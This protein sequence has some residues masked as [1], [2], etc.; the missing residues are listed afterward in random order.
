MAVRTFLWVTVGAW[1]LTALS[2]MSWKVDQ[3]VLRD[4]AERRTKHARNDEERILAL[5]EWVFQN[6]GDDKVSHYF[7]H[8]SLGPTPVQVLAGG[9]DC[10][11]KSRLLSAL[12]ARLGIRSTLAMQFPCATCKPSHTIVEARAEFGW[13]AVDP[14]YNLAF[15]KESGGYYSLR[16]LRGNPTVLPR[17]LK[18]LARRRGPADKINFYDIKGLHYG[19][20]RTVNWQ[21]DWLTNSVA[22]WLSWF[23]G[24]PFLIRRPQ[25]LED[26]KYLILL[27]ALFMA[28]GLTVVA[29]GARTSRRELMGFFSRRPSRDTS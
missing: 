18:E 26:P 13:M 3:W 2:L 16:E 20:V 4:F 19:H 11:D 25:F 7:L 10:A 17:R 23:L 5:L 22:G 27:G 1:G 8:R 12:L 6:D 9:G 14:S 29:V 21:K 15:P 24:D 28:L